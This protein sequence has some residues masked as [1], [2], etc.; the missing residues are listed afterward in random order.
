MAAGKWKVFSNYMPM[1]EKKQYTV[2]R[3]KDM[4]K[5]LHSGNIEYGMME[6]YVDDKA[7]CE[8]LAA[9]MNE[10]EERTGKPYFNPA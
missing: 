4:D 9:E 7:Y 6:G 3:Q 8:K 5:P 2:A 1:L 10:T